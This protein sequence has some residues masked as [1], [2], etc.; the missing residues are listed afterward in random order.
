MTNLA[1]GLASNFINQQPGTLDVKAVK[2]GTT[3]EVV[4]IP[5][6]PLSNGDVLTVYIANDANGRPVSSVSR[7]QQNRLFLYLPF[8]RKQ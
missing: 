7:D 1:Y 4:D 5:P 8:V 6:I 2:T 3:N